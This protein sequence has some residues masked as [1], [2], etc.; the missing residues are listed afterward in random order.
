[1][2]SITASIV[3]FQMKTSDVKPRQVIDT[4]LINSGA[5]LIPGEYLAANPRKTKEG[6]TYWTSEQVRELLG[7]SL[8]LAIPRDMLKDPDLK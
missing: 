5:V 7:K 8:L 2:L 6:W 4:K 3:G 1:M